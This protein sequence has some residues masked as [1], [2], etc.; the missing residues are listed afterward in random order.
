MQHE[1]WVYEYVNELMRRAPHLAL[2]LIDLFEC[3][4]DKDE[5]PQ[6]MSKFRDAG[7]YRDVIRLLR[8]LTVELRTGEYGKPKCP[9]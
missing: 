6:L 7:I 5:L 8:H 4:V 3:E 2:H 9:S 1:P